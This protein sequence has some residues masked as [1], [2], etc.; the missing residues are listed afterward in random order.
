[1]AQAAAGLGTLAVVEE[2][3]EDTAGP[4]SAVN[5]KGFIFSK[6]IWILYGSELSNTGMNYPHV[7]KNII[8]V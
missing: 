5:T 7:D 3:Q 4:L 6:V 8:D 2:K 1:M